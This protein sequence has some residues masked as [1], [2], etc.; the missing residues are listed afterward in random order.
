M[1]FTPCYS[2][3]GSAAPG[4]PV[5]SG[6]TSSST[7]NPI[8]IG[9]ADPNPANWPVLI[10]FC[11]GGTATVV[12]EANGGQLSSAGVPPSGEWID[13]SNGG[14]SMTSGQTAAKRIPPN[15]PYIRTRNTAL[16]GATVTSYVP[17]ICFPNGRWASASRP[18]VSSN[19]VA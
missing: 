16:S 6:T 10:I 3:G 8:D 7:G 11:A 4:W 5:V 19:Q 2:F 18:S 15:V 13:I 1:K 12:I 9:G 17:A 14:L